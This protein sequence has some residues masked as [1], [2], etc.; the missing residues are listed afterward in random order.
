[1]NEVEQILSKPQMSIL[2]STAAINLFLAGTGCFHGDTLIRTDKGYVKIKDIQNGDRVLT[3]N[4]V[5]KGT[6]IKPV[7][8]KYLYKT[9]DIKQKCGI[10][11]LNNNTKIICTDEHRFYFKKSWIAISELARLKI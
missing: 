6:E 11:V 3:F 10:F 1:M 5:T 4:E 8:N 7:I 9:G 2:K